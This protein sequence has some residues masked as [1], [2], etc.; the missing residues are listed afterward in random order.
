MSTRRQKIQLELAFGAQRPGETVDR[1]SEGSEVLAAEHQPESLAISGQLMVEVLERENLKKALRR[2]QRNKGAPGVDGMTV[3]E[4]PDYLRE[5]WP[6]IRVQLQKG[7]YNPQPVRRVEI[8]KPNGGTRKLGIPTV[9]DRWLQQAVLQVLQRQ[10]DPTFSE[11]SYGFRPGRSAHQAIAQAQK[12]VREGYTVIVDLDLE[13]FFDLVLHDR[14]MARVAER[15]DDKAVLKLLRSFLKAGVAME[16]GLVSPTEIG[17]PQGGPISPLLSNLILDELDHE[18]ERRGHRFCRYADD[19]NI[20][21]RSERAGQRVMASITRY[22][23]RRLKL[24]VNK[25]KSQV[26]PAWQCEF[27]GFSITRGPARK[28]CIG[29]KALHRFKERV[30]ELTRRTRGVSLKRVVAD[31]AQYLRGWIAYF[32]FCDARYALRDLDSWIRRRLRCFIWKQWK[33]FRRRRR[34]L[35]ERG[36]PEAPAS[37]T[38]ARSRGCWSTSNVPPLRIAFPVTYFNSLGLPRLFGSRA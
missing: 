7:T 25:L 14:L 36:I 21:V 19:V 24:R 23:T 9:V 10:W 8:P 3:D 28:R 26:V 4:L 2:V 20:Y 16:D 15:V 17:T 33:I 5:H 1:V 35:M 30:R 18:L 12:Y 34:G 31:L 22:I 29:S 27:L 37:Q 11:H 38:A 13:K 32:G 6:T